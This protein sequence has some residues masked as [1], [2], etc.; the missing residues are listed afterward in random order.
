ME[1]QP[2]QAYILVRIRGETIEV[3]S[4]KR[5]YDGSAIAFQGDC[6][7][8]AELDNK[9][10]KNLW[11]R[12]LRIG[13]REANEAKRIGVLPPDWEPPQSTLIPR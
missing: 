7:T 9:A 13:F 10:W 5:F 8:T 11:L 2:N 4:Y 3:V 1:P 6:C 12:F